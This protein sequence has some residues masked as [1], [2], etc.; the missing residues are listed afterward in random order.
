MVSLLVVLLMILT[1]GRVLRTTI[2]LASIRLRL[3]VIIMW[4]STLV[5]LLVVSF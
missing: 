2:N 5:V 3:L 4:T 1:L